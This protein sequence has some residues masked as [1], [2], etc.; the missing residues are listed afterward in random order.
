MKELILL[1]A[2]I[3]LIYFT[4]WFVLA[5]IVKRN[6]V[7][8]IAWGLGYLVLAAYYITNYEISGRAILITVLISIW[9][10]RLAIFV[11]QRNRGKKED[12]RYLNWRNTW[13]L[14]YLRSYFQIYLLQATM[15]LLIISPFTILMSQGSQPDLNYLD[16]IGATVWLIGFLFEAVG[17]YQLSAFKKKPENKGKII[18]SGLWKYTR[19]PNYFGEVSLWWGIFIITASSPGFLYGI[20]GPLTITVLILFVSGVPM[21]EEKYKGNPEFEA[22]KKKTSKFFPLPSRKN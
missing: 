20:L 2:I 8:D 16:L 11:F 22:Y 18:E 7:V 5:I 21:L 1:S 9:G 4:S 19:H 13:K 3:I 17:D 6:D 12:F 10:I 14:F 15:L